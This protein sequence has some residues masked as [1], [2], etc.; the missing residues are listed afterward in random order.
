MQVTP[1]ISG[2]ASI[3]LALYFS[4]NIKMILFPLAVPRLDHFMKQFILCLITLST[5]LFP[6]ACSRKIQATTATLEMSIR[7][8]YEAYLKDGGGFFEFNS[9]QEFTSIL[10]GNNACKVRYMVLS[11]YPLDKDGQIIDEWGR[12]LHITRPE[13]TKLEIRSAGPDGKFDTPDDIVTVH[14]RL[15]IGA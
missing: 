4:T 1:A 3:M 10:S 2:P 8:D 14:P 15:K 6:A 5:L 12:P 13:K 11:T 7:V 9:Q